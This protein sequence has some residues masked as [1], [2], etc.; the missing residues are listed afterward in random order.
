M[1]QL[2]DRRYENIVA[3][4]LLAGHPHRLKT[5]CVE[6]VV[7]ELIFRHRPQIDTLT[8]GTSI[9]KPI[10]SGLF[11]GPHFFNASISGGRIEEMMAAYQLAL[12]CRL[13]PRHILIEIDGRALGQRAPMAPSN[14]LRRAFRRLAIPDETE[15]PR[16]LSAIWHALVPPG[17][18]ACSAKERGPFYPYDELIS[19]R[20]FQFTIGFLVRRWQARNEKPREIVSQ[21]G[22]ANE[23]LMYPDGSLEW[24]DNALIQTPESIR[25]KFDEVNTASIAAEEYRPVPEKCRLYE[26]F[27]ANLVQSGVDVEFL[28]LPPNPW[29]FEKAADWHRPDRPGSL[30]DRR[31]PTFLNSPQAISFRP[32]VTR[33]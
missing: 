18:A 9:A 27:V 11:G 10:H 4:D 3:R 15:R 24:W 31:Q 28:M 7:D 26:A 5:T 22:E 20:Y 29:Y 32:W 21:F 17:D 33:S 2:V 8:L 14:L 19:P 1:G 6:L 25:L 12:D 13:R 23:A 30:G 16:I